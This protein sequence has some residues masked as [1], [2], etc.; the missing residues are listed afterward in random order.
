MEFFWFFIL[1]I[2]E[3]LLMG[4][5]WF[6]ILDVLGVLLIGFFWF[7]ILDMLEFLE[8]FILEV[9]E[10]DWF[11]IELRF[12]V[13]VELRSE[14]LEDEK[15]GFGIE[16]LGWEGWLIKKF[17]W[18]K[19]L[20]EGVLDELL[21]RFFKGGILENESGELGIRGRLVSK[22][23]CEEL[24]DEVE[25]VGWIWGEIGCRLGVGGGGGGWELIGGVVGGVSLG[26][27]GWWE[28]GVG[29]G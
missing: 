14:I 28:L 7:F 5:F 3:L 20:I 2:L 26:V 1:G 22:G 25:D 10:L 9:L 19:V 6:F 15:D 21:G 24:W 23:F 18:F 16:I 8:F 27:V 12:K 4:F 29:E 13:R 11:R 17:C